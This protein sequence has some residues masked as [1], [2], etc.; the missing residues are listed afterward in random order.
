MA[1]CCGMSGYHPLLNQGYLGHAPDAAIYCTIF[2][3][4]HVGR[5]HAIRLYLWSCAWAKDPQVSYT[6]GV[7]LGRR[8][9]YVAPARRLFTEEMY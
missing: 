2:R 3:S 6:R 8:L 9:K 1:D 4:N 5:E 7:Y